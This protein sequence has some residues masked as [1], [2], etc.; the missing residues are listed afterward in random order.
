MNR[1]TRSC[2]FAALLMGM[3]LSP[4]VLAQDSSYRPTGQQIPPPACYTLMESFE[5]LRAGPAPAA[6]SAQ[7]HQD[8]LSDVQHWRAERRIRIGYDEHA[9]Q[10]RRWSGRSPASCSRR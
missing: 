7:S 5:D 6:C 1:L 10:S 8:W 2:S 3:A 4:A 9:T